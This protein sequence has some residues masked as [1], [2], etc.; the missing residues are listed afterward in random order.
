M[1]VLICDK[2]FEHITGRK[3]ELSVDV[4]ECVICGEIEKGKYENQETT[5]ECL[6]RL[7]DEKRKCENNG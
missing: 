6:I 4:D 3:Q 7:Y 2:C 1:R 5:I